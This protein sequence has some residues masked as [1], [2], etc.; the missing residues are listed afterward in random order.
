MRGWR[1][2]DISILIEARSNSFWSQFIYVESLIYKDFFPQNQ[3]K[4]S[5]INFVND[6]K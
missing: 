2:L 1:I 6:N 5:V 4:L 3:T